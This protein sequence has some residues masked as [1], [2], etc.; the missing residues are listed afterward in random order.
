MKSKYKEYD[1][2]FPKLYGKGVAKMKLKE[3]T[4]RLGNN[5]Y[6]HLYDIK[7]NEIAKGLY[8][9]IKREN[10]RIPCYTENLENY[11]SVKVLEI[12]PLDLGELEITIGYE[13]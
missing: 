12:N 6:I 10:N 1:C 3:L 13:E 7:G 11:I 2:W 4:E 5:T 9:F 8:S